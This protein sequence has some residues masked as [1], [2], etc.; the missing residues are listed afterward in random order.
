VFFAPSADRAPVDVP[1]VVLTEARVIPI[2]LDLI[3]LA[4][5]SVG[6]IVFALRARRS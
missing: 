6:G 3:A 4:A 5:L 1:P 2:P